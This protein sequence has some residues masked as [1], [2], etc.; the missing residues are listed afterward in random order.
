MGNKAC[1]STASPYDIA[2]ANYDVA[3]EVVTTQNRAK[4]ENASL[5]E[6]ELSSLDQFE[7]YSYS[8]NSETVIQ[9]GDSPAEDNLKTTSNQKKLETPKVKQNLME[10]AQLEI[11]RI[12]KDSNRDVII[13]GELFRYRPGDKTRFIPRWCRVTRSS[14]V[15][16]KNRV[17]AVSHE[18]PLATVP[19]KSIRQA[20]P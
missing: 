10:K 20:V 1:C 12:F 18:K 11:E 15:I 8:S 6:N 3:A 19:L 7:K 4:I 5:G 17:S 2:V 14:L 13:E 16:F 9:S